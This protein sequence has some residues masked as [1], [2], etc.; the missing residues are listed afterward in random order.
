M[1]FSG[2]PPP[3]YE[4]SSLN[5]RQ[6]SI[7]ISPLT[8]PAIAPPAYHNGNLASSD[9]NQGRNQT[10]GLTGDYTYTNSSRVPEEETQESSTSQA[11]EGSWSNL[12]SKKYAQIGILVLFLFV[13]WVTSM[14]LRSDSDP[15]YSVQCP[16]KENGEDA[17]G[18]QCPTEIRQQNLEGYLTFYCSECWLGYHLE[19]S[20]Q[21]DFRKDQSYDHRGNYRCEINRC[22]CDY[23]EPRVGEGCLGPSSSETD[24]ESTDCI[25]CYQGYRLENTG[26][27]GYLGIWSRQRQKCVGEHE[28]DR[29]RLREAMRDYFY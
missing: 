23:G 8:A 6:E 7:G 21:L 18:E 5:T 10:S 4:A 14:I 13:M 24:E 25:S 12:G 28:D 15:N 26:Y 19:G 3:S 1:D 2:V 27:V 29:P 16:C 20:G 22:R 17:W 11:N 9:N